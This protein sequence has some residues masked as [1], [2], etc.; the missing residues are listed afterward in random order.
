METSQLP[1]SYGMFSYMTTTPFLNFSRIFPDW[2]P[3]H[4]HRWWIHTRMVYLPMAYL[5]GIRYKA[6]EN[7]LILS[8]RQVRIRIISSIQ[9]CLLTNS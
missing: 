5:Y 2:L 4:P 3:F 8:L 6:E 1:Q 7:D 9:F